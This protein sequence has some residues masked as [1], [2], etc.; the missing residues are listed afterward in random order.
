MMKLAH[1]HR[2]DSRSPGRRILTGCLV[3]ALLLGFS[4]LGLKVACAQEAGADRSPRVLVIGIDGVRPDILLKANTP[5][6][7][8]LIRTGAFSARAQTGLPTLSGPSWASLLTGVWKEKHG[9][10][11]NDFPFPENRLD[12]Y[13]DFLTRIEQVRP[14]LRTFA[15]A[16]WPPLIEPQTSEEGATAPPVL[17]EAIDARVALD[18]GQT[19]WAEADERS[20]EAAVEELERNDPAALFVYLGNPDE[21]S[22]HTGSIEDEYVAAIERADRHVGRLLEAIRARPTYA[23]EDWLILVSTDHGRLP[24]GG[25]GGTTQEERTI[26]FLANGSR[27]PQGT[28]PTPPEI[29]DVA[30]TALHYL[31][32][33][34]RPEWELDGEPVGLEESLK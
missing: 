18:G 17:S 26:F 21:V 8:E 23:A 33:G 13:P 10:M 25:H 12:R 4:P 19:G 14:E 9:I 3:G 31:G 2:C 32:I 22:H 15:V 29:V 27:I 28:I 7:E 20:V 34:P 11:S 24:N 30:A 1:A 5:N 6:L 16:D